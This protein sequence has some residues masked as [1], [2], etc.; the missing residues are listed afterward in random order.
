MKTD[1]HVLIKYDFLICVGCNGSLE[2]VVLAREGGGVV[3]SWHV[4]FEGVMNKFRDMLSLVV[5]ILRSIW[6]E[7]WRLVFEGKKREAGMIAKCARSL[8][9]EFL[10]CVNRGLVQVVSSARHSSLAWCRR[11]SPNKG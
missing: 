4:W 11:L 5:R 8:L 1:V 7:I 10:K 2:K 6:K 9:A 3:D